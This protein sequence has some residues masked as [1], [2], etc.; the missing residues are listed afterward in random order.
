MTTQEFIRLRT[1]QNSVNKHRSHFRSIMSKRS[2]K[3]RGKHVGV[4]LKNSRIHNQVGLDVVFN[5]P[6][7]IKRQYV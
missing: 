7:W 5:A 3:G 4:P 2:T 1:L 6:G